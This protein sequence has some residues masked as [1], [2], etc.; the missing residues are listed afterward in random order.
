MTPDGGRMAKDRDRISLDQEHLALVNG[1]GP[2][3]RERIMDSGMPR[4]PH[5]TPHATPVMASSFAPS[6]HKYA[7]G[8]PSPGHFLGQSFAVPIQKAPCRSPTTWVL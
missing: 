5:S 3:L 8:Y 2:A 6:H 4:T 1:N 7:S